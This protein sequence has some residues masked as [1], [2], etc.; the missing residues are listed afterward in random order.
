MSLVAWSP[1]WRR[2][3]CSRDDDWMDSV[4]DKLIRRRRNHR[5]HPKGVQLG[6]GTG[7]TL[8]ETLIVIVVIGI[9]AAI[10]VITYRMVTQRAQTAQ[11]IAAADTWE[12]VLE[13]QFTLTGTLP[14]ADPAPVCLGDSSANFPATADM[15]AG[16]CFEVTG[17]ASQADFSQTFTDG[18]TS[19]AVSG[20]LPYVAFNSGTVDVKARGIAANIYQRPNGYQV[21]FYFYVPADAKCGRA[22]LMATVGN[23]SA[24]QLYIDIG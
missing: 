4:G 18:L 14:I 5:D 17:W 12:K 1:S 16:R 7:F 24:C 15:P 21:I 8:V 23:Y 11:Y 22:V 6:A 19:S 9:L 2:L 10:V 3:R 13:T 20:T